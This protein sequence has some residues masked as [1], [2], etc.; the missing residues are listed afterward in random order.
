MRE[1]EP[2]VGS[3]LD[4]VTPQVP[5]AEGAAALEP[6][7][8]SGVP[9]GVSGLSSSGTRWLPVVSPVAQGGVAQS[10][11]DGPFV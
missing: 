5:V 6:D 2:Y 9:H 7:S 10:P 11:V 8:G 4:D 3:E 1:P